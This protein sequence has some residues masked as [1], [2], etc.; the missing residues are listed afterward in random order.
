[1]TPIVQDAGIGSHRDAG[2]LPAK[3]ERA[4]F[5]HRAHQEPT[6][7][8]GGFQSVLS[9]RSRVEAP[10]VPSFVRDALREIRTHIEEHHVQIEGPPFSIRHPTMRHGVEVEVGW[11]V[12][13][14]HGSGR[15]A[16]CTIPIGMA[17]RGPDHG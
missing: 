7:P 3:E 13:R 4:T 8:A 14:S 11:P 15:I 12:G 6:Q 17:H 10:D 2:R 9:I 1:M 16:S 5:E